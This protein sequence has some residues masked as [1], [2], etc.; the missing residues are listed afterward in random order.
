MPEKITFDKSG[1]NT[2]AIRGVNGDA[3]LDI[4]LRLSKYL[5]NI[6]PQGHQT[7]KRIINPLLGFKSFWSAQKVIT[8]IETMN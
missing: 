4:E 2:A 7:V 5:N 3:C 1:T 6:V 8:R